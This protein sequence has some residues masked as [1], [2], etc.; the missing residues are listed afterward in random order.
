[1]WLPTSIIELDGG[2]FILRYVFGG[3]NGQRLWP[4]LG[5]LSGDADA[6]EIAIHEIEAPD[7]LLWQESGIQD[8]GELLE[9]EKE[10]R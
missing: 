9:F 8:P 7:R 4:D 5:L 3:G 1:M 10:E 2:G 6:L